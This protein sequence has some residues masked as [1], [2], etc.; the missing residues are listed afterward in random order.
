MKK[1]F[2]YALMLLS[3]FSFSSCSDDEDSVAGTNREWMTMFICDNN[4]GKGDDYPYNCKNEGVNGNDIHLYWYG[5]DDCA[6]YQIRQALQPNVSGGAEAWGSS[7]EKGLLLL[8]TIVGPDVLDLVIKDQQ[9]STDFRFAIRVLS[10]KDDNVTDFSHASKWYGHGDGRQWAEWLGITTADRYATPF[11]V[12]VDASKTTETTMRVMLKRNFNDVIEGVSD[13][14]KVVYRERFEMNGDNFVY[15]WLEV[16]ASPNNPTSTVGDKWKKYKLTE[17]DFNRGYVDIDGLQKNSVYVINVRNENVKIKWDSYYNTCSVRSDGEPGEP[18]LIE[19]KLA[20]APPAKLDDETDENYAAVVSSHEAAI[21]KYNA[22][23]IDDIL[24]DFIS[25][26]NFAE[27][28]EFYLEGGKTYCMYR[29]LT[30]C[31]GF[32]LRTRPEDV[33]AG[34]RAKVLLGGMSV[35]GANVNSM[36]LM[37]GRQPQSGEGGEIYMKMLEF[38]DIDF[39]CPLARTY[40]DQEAGVGGATGNYFINMYPNGMAVHLENFVIKNCTFKR[41]VR[42]FIREQGSNYKIWDNVLIED[43]QFFDCGYYSNG[44][45]G[46]NWVAGSGNNANSNLYKNFVVRNNTFFDCPFPSFFNETKQSA[47]KSGAW[48]ITFSNNTLVNWNTRAA[49]NIFNMRNIPDGSTFTVKNNLIVLTKQDGDTRKMTMG[50]ADIRKTMTMPDGTNGHVTLNFENNYSTNTFLT[51]GQ[52]FSTNAWTATKNNFG[53]LVNNGSATL[54]G[55]LEVVTDDISPLELMT[56]PNPPHKAK[57]DSDQ[58]M[59]RA[60]ALDGTGGEHG[61]NL[62]YNKNDKVLNSQIYKLGIGDSRWRK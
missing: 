24:T 27:G 36:N 30:T 14:D 53:T 58:F 25:D 3:G 31:K 19:H 32:V 4:R 28:Q 12:Y 61:A 42:G 1:Y 10:K 17:E 5:V 16:E 37:F 35:T 15:Q 47:W 21:S 2:L 29:N 40:G 59:H 43:C 9:Y 56:S 20:T 52:I 54:N 41:M 55:T 34:K 48:N 45:G 8:D 46:Y 57:S 11:C 51:N 44:A 50:G 39:D 38:H 26:V 49:G 23:Q 22:M 6:G 18:V 60:D 62:F 33:A 13:E 7:A